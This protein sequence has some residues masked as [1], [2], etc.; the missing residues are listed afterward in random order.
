MIKTE[1]IWTSG[2]SSRTKSNNEHPCGSIT[3]AINCPHF[4]SLGVTICGVLIPS[5]F[6]IPVKSL[7]KMWS[8]LLP[9]CRYVVDNASWPEDTPL[10]P[11]RS[12]IIQIHLLA[13]SQT[14]PL[15]YRGR[16]SPLL[17][18]LPAR[19]WDMRHIVASDHYR[20]TDWKTLNRLCEAI[21]KIKIRP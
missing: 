6:V 19:E 13:F 1:G 5:S 7:R 11:R 16:L 4:W 8:S 20:T 14:C 10:Q 12:P 15:D 21:R 17:H 2:L 9:G 3:W 18:G